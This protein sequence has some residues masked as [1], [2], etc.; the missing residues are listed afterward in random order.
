MARRAITQ[1]LYNALV[2]AFRKL[3][4][5][6]SHASKH[7]GC[8]WQTAK[9]GWLKGWPH[10]F[11]WAAPIEAVIKEEADNARVERAKQHEIDRLK[12]LEAR[13]LARQDAV[14]ANTEEAKMITASRQNALMMSA[15]TQQLLGGA[16]PLA[17]RGLELLKADTTST[18]PQIL[19]YIESVTGILR[20]AN[21]AM[22][23]AM[24]AERTK[25]GNPLQAVGAGPI[26]DVS[27]EDALA[28]LEGLLVTIER[29][30][31]TGVLDVDLN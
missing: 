24:Q 2:D 8:D 27:R 18:L 19:R 23:D 30:K 17:R 31:T 5:N 11:S 25:V 15:I 21:A 22:L 10:R 26:A 28:E 1:Q 7:A 6:Y 4:G 16:I 9:N 13:D 12:Q 29:A 20:G 3:P 14:K